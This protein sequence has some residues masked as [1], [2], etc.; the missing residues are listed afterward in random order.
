MI[1]LDDFFQSGMT[2][3]CGKPFRLSGRCEEPA[4]LRVLLNGTVLAGLSLPAG[5]FSLTLPPQPAQTGAELRLE[6]AGQT[7]V[8]PDLDF[9]EVWIAGGQSNMEFQLRHDLGFRT[10]LREGRSFTEDDPHLRTFDLPHLAYPEAPADPIRGVWRRA[11]ADGLPYF[12]AVGYYFGAMLRKALGVPVAIVACN[13]GGTPASAWT[14]RERL[15]ADPALAFLVEEADRRA[16]TADRDAEIR[17]AASKNAAVSSRPAWVGRMLDHMMAG[18]MSAWD[19]FLNDRIFPLYAKKYDRFQKEVFWTDSCR[20]CALYDAMLTKLAGTAARG[21]IWYQGES[22][23]RRAALYDRSFTAVIESWRALW[24]EE[25]P[26]LFVQLAPFGHWGGCLGTDYP[27]LREKQEQVSKTVPSVWMASIMDAG[28]EDDIHPK[29]KQPVGERL[30]LL[31]RGKVYGEDLPCEA[32]ELD[33]VAWT[34]GSFVLTFR[35]AEGGLAGAAGCAGS[36][37]F[38]GRELLR[39]GTPVTGFEA[40]VSGDRFLI[41][42]EDPLPGVYTFKYLRVPY[43]KADV[44]AA[45][46][47]RFGASRGLTPKPFETTYQL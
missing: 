3:Q 26:F 39:D 22:D 37:G 27:L 40:R 1:T 9:G 16:E 38:A 19:R 14:S 17:R 7:L 23:D 29:D 35:N 34:D 4:E 8:L 32:P 46:C 30:A 21:V 13:W 2:F 28:E 5:P 42:P 12:S 44:Y 10:A 6:T 33:S 20:P 31:A 15:L 43:V 24:Q 47:L 25:L 11:D 41:T 45:D 18:E 36:A